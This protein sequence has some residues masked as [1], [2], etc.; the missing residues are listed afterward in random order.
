MT[1]SVLVALPAETRVLERVSVGHE[2]FWLFQHEGFEDEQLIIRLQT[3]IYIE[4]LPAFKIIR[5]ALK[6]YNTSV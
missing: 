5:G 4:A 6:V 2:S 3:A 1:K